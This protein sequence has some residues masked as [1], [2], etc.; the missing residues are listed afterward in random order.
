MIFYA[1][2]ALLRLPYRA[3]PAARSQK[4][5]RCDANTGARNTIYK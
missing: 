5:E 2:A 4:G 3:F 1:T